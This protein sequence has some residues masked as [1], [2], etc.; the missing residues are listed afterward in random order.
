[1]KTA[2]WNL[3]RKV[4]QSQA[5]DWAQVLP[6]SH[7]PDRSE[8]LSNAFFWVAAEMRRE[9]SL[10]LS[11]RALEALEKSTKLLRVANQLES[12]GNLKESGRLREEGRT[13]RSISVWLM[14]QANDAAGGGKP[15]RTNILQR[16]VH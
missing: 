9:L 16:S 12:Q 11:E 1:M 7:I 6:L 8:L 13:Q 5:G 3:I 4:S 15:G 14:A 10:T 2:T